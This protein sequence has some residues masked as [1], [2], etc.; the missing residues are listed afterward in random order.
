MTET[1]AAPSRY[2]GR[3]IKRINDPQLLAGGGRF[4]DDLRSRL[5]QPIKLT[6][7]FDRNRGMPSAAA[8][9]ATCRPTAPTP[10]PTA[11]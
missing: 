2:V 7:M 1:S 6:T 10:M 8:C 5:D 9:K 11:C 3:S 4:V